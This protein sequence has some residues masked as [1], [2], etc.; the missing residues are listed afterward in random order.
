MGRGCKREDGTQS[1][2]SGAGRNELSAEFMGSL[3]TMD[4]AS[5][6]ATGRHHCGSG[7][8]DLGRTLHTLSRDLAP[9]PQGLDL[10]W[11]LEIGGA[12]M[13]S[14]SPPGLSELW[15]PNL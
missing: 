5:L 15:F 2:P 8:Q 10:T 12:R 3:E 1:A 13:F 14:I 4:M 11:R 7:G 6:L 9:G